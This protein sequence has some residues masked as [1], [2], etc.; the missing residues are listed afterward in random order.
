MERGFEMKGKSEFNEREN[1]M[2]TITKSKSM[3]GSRGFLLSLLCAGVVASFLGGCA[4]GP[5]A[6][7][8]DSGYYYPAAYYRPG[9]G[10]DNGYYGYPYSYYGN[11]GF[12]YAPTYS[13]YGYAPTYG[14]GRTVVRRSGVRSTYNRTVVR[15]S[16]VRVHRATNTNY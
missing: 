5:Y 13:Y 7:A 12:G 2:N 8:Y 15:G 11:Y 14:R 9:Y 4:E 6:T 10:Y 3:N 16:R 1:L